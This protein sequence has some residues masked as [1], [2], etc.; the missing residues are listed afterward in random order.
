MAGIKFIK[1]TKVL[2]GDNASPSGLSTH[3]LHPEFQT[4]MDIDMVTGA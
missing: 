3:S 1:K 2:N 4:H